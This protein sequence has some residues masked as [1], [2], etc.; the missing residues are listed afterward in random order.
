MENGMRVVL[1][2][3]GD[4]IA[5]LK[6]HLN[7][8]NTKLKDAEDT[9]A[10]KREEVYGLRKKVEELESENATL[11]VNEKTFTQVMDLVNALE[12]AGFSMTDIMDDLLRN[13]AFSEA[14]NKPLEFGK[15]DIPSVKTES[16]IKTGIAT[17]KGSNT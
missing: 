11:K 8:A 5:S 2:T 1:E 6:S 14:L 9:L 15:F 17:A 12:A 13:P 7:W 10:K 3:L 16:E 4:Q